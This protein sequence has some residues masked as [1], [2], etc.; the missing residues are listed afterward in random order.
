[1]AMDSQLDSSMGNNI[2]AYTPNTLE[3]E[4]ER[5]VP[6]IKDF[7]KDV[8]ALIQRAARGKEIGSGN[9][10]VERVREEVS[11]KLQEAKMWAGKMLEALGNPFPA[12]LADRAKVQ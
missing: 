10:D 12:E 9:Y 6:V 3:Q 8:D 2:G 1:M 5:H 11:K 4:R 7:R